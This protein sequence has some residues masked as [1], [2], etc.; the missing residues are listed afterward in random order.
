[1]QQ[2]TDIKDAR[3]GNSA[4]N[5]IILG[6]LWLEGFQYRLSSPKGIVAEEASWIGRS[7]FE[8]PLEPNIIF[9]SST[10]Y[11]C[12]ATTVLL[13]FHSCYQFRW[14]LS[15]GHVKVMPED[16]RKKGSQN[17]ASHSELRQ[18]ELRLVVLYYF[19]WVAL[20]LSI[21]NLVELATITHSTFSAVHAFDSSTDSLV[22][23]TSNLA[24][25]NIQVAWL[26]VPWRVPVLDFLVVRIHR[27][28]GH[29]S[30]ALCVG[31]SG[32]WVSSAVSFSSKV[33]LLMDLYDTFVPEV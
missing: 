2:T 18:L 15:G 30:S 31:F 19:C 16:A 10:H 21:D 8:S 3:F 27:V 5:M 20:E 1:M 33:A 29:G 25:R 26:L 14:M 7:G 13:F 23:L 11:M 24:L 32:G 17:E 4:H 28:R 6:G 22:D 9:I 12:M